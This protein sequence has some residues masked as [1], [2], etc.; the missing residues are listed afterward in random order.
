MTESTDRAFAIKIALL[1]IRFVS[2]NWEEIKEIETIV[3]TEI[4]KNQSTQTRLM[5]IDE[6]QKEGTD[7]VET[8]V[9]AYAIR[10]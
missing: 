5:K 7:I 3:N 4:L 6:A 10:D 2:S 1:F 8:G 9:T